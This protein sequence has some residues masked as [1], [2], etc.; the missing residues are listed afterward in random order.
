MEVWRRKYRDGSM[1]TEVWGW[2]YGN[3]SM[4]VSEL[5]N[6]GTGMGE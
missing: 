2:K 4:R 3:G 6:G 1:E 5:G